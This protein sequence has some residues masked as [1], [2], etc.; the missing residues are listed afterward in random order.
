MDLEL[1][2][3]FVEVAD[4][5]GFTAASASLGL[6]RSSVSRRVAKLEEQLGVQLLHRTTR[7]VV[8]SSAGEAFYARVAA[9]LAAIDRAIVEVPEQRDEPTGEL[10]VT[11]PHDLAIEACAEAFAGFA[12]RYPRVSLVVHA[13]SQSHDLV[14]EGL[15]VALRV[16]LEPLPDSPL[17]ARRLASAS[18]GL[19]ATPGYLQRF[20][21][22]RR[23]DEASS[24]AFIRWVGPSPEDGTTV[25][26]TDDMLV[27]R[28]MVRQGLGLGFLP[29]FLARTDVLE[30]R[31][32]RTGPAD[33]EQAF[34]V[35]AMYPPLRPLPRKLRAF[36]D[37]LVEWFRAHPLS[38]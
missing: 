1:V 36:V 11:V 33:T 37:Y 2:R 18:G 21:R 28:A 25:F 8:L 17:R 14:A 3:V 23:S 30:G 31:L 22:F 7:R 32:V 27:V 4:R 9:P 29:E 6:P 26:R 13:S 15:D 38:G 34:A 5:G 35:F 24:H 12:R 20:G 16:T 19:Y 10:R